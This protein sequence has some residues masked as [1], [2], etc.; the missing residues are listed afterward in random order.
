MSH[1]GSLASQV[2]QWIVTRIAETTPFLAPDES[3]LQGLVEVYRGSEAPGGQAFLDAMFARHTRYACVH[4]NG[5][6][7]ID[8][9]EGEIAEV[10]T[11]IVWVAVTHHRAVGMA[12]TGETTGGVGSRVIH[13]SN[14]LRE[15]IRQ[16]THNLNPGVGAYGYFSG[17]AQFRGGEIVFETKGRFIWQGTIEVRE[18][19]EQ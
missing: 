15:I 10:G 4:F 3:G 19:P 13:G 9:E 6:R 11:Y 12:R 17:P 1:D 8:L 7:S 14:G 18:D 5:S 16:A 2:E